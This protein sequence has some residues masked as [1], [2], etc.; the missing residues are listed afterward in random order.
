[1]NSICFIYQEAS[2]SSESNVL[3]KAM[4][5]RKSMFILCGEHINIKVKKIKT[6]PDAHNMMVI[7]AVL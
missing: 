3:S 4:H 5:Y 2:I 7:C 1:M 6:I